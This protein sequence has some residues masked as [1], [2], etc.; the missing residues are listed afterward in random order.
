VVL[1]QHITGYL[2]SKNQEGVKYNGKSFVLEDKICRKRR[3][4]KDKEEDMMRLLADFGVSDRRGA[5]DK[6]IDAQK[7]DEVETRKLKIK[8]RKDKKDGY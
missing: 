6:L 3:G 5:L 8:P 1:E 7:G 4:K 2:D